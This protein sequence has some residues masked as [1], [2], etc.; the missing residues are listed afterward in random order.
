[1]NQSDPRRDRQRPRRPQPKQ[2][3]LFLPLFLLGIFL[4][5]VAGLAFFAFF[6]MSFR[7][8]RPV[9]VAAKS[10]LKLQV[11]GV[12][13]EF[14]PA[15]PV[16]VLLDRRPIVFLDYLH[17]VNTAR[18]DDRIEGIFLEIGP[19]SLSWA[20]MEE[21]RV[22]LDKFRESG[23][24]V[25]SFGEIWQ[26]QEYFLASV[27]N[28]AFMAPEGIL[29]LDG[30]MSRV[31]F[32]ADIFK[33]YGIRVHVEAIGE[34][35]SYGDAY[36]RTEMSEPH[37]EA[38]L[39]LLS[40]IENRL[41]ESVTASRDLD[42]GVMPDALKS[43]IY[44][45]PKAV[46]LGLLD[47]VAYADEI[48][49]KMAEKLG[50]EQ[51]SSVRLINGSSYLVSRPD[52][53]QGGPDKI[54]LIYAIG[55]I[56][57]GSASQGLFGGNVIASDSFIRTLKATR[58]DPRVKAIV[59]RIDSPGG[60][61]LASDVMWR[62]IKRTREMGIPV[63]A[64]MGGVAASGG[65]YMAMACDKIVAEPTTITG[66]IG[67]VSMR[68]DFEDFYEEFLLHVDVVK[69]A[70]SADFFDPHR[71][72]TES[73][74]QSFHQRA[75]ASYRG[76]VQKAADSRGMAYE[77]M[78]LRARG[79]VWSG[80]DAQGNNLIDRLGGLNEAIELAALQAKLHDYGVVRYPKDEDFWTLIRNGQF[81]QVK[82]KRLALETVS[83]LLPEEI[84]SILNINRSQG[85]LP[86]QL[87]ALLPYRIEIR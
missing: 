6:V 79:R 3:S 36:T 45:T 18:R 73:E 44:E 5:L 29:L 62:E 47:G 82:S 23:K 65:Y 27:A 24:W 64:S 7:T 9:K 22:A 61:S 13:P 54:A 52:F 17:M 70:P 58:E 31:T 12:I 20:Q 28:Q 55:T 26:E 71:G 8:Q 42:A 41:I 32:Y 83:D 86:A 43:A 57:S 25:I 21:L 14:V 68:V 10:V 78:E 11:S 38:T 59:L 16:N 15:N 85:N 75:L 37:R 87:L 63:V 72:L 51:K 49:G 39:A 53:G 67:V 35:K 80:L 74:I 81:T 33:K 30:L 34:Y 4:F 77:D 19:S 84:K 50:L 46:D 1:M 40:S 2:R 56:Q 76:F 60:S 48:L 69:T 66:S